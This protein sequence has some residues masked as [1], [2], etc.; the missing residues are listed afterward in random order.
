M[1]SNYGWIITVD[2]TE[3]NN[4]DR[5]APVIGPFGVSDCMMRDLVNGA[6]LDFR[7]YD[8][9]GEL[10]Y[11]GRWIG[12]VDSELM[13]GPLDDFGMPNTGCTEIRYKNAEGEFEIL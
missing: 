12:P 13:F 8:G 10:Y 5:I 9:D 7:M 1:A 4:E 3:D 2:H 6:G 11:E